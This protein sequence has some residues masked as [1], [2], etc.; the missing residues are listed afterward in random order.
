MNF[1]L[2]AFP[3][4][5]LP[6]IVKTE[7]ESAPNEHNI[8]QSIKVEVKEEHYDDQDCVVKC[9]LDFDEGEQI[10]R[11]IKVKVEGKCKC[12]VNDN[13]QYIFVCLFFRCFKRTTRST[14]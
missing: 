10:D 6:L 1:T 3:P 14:L 12:C 9:E 8:M 5:Q 4:D 11:K 7:S 2:F 13:L